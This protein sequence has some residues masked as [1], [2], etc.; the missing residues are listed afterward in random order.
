MIPSNRTPLHPG[1]ILLRE[2]LE[3]FGLTQ[4]AL[5]QHL[6]IPLQRLN[7]IVRGKRAV[8]PT[9]AWLLSQAF[10]TSPEFWLHLRAAHDL[11]VARPGRKI[12]P[13]RKVG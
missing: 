6:E 3:P 9:T 11:V 5:A 12:R 4:V 2:F 10:Q 8:T 13:V 7:G 1:E